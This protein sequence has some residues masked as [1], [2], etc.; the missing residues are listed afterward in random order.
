MN[1]PGYLYGLERAGDLLGL[2]FFGKHDWYRE[3]AEFLIG[4]QQ[5]GGSWPGVAKGAPN[6][7][8][9]TELLRTCFALLFLKRAT[10]PPSVPLG[11]VVTG[12]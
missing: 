6:A 12:G 11:P 2:R 4:A 1:D 10:I 8:G 3:G 7:H 9:E 5:A